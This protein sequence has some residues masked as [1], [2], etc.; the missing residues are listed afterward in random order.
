MDHISF[1]YRSSSHLAF[2]HV[3]AE[4]GAFERHQLDVEYDKKISREDAH[5]LVP[6]GKVEFTSG[7]HVS[8]YAARARGDNWIYLAQ[9]VSVNQLCMVVRQDSE[10]NSVKDLR[11]K[12]FATK[13]RHPALNDWL[14]LKQ[15]GLDVDK[16]EVEIIKFGSTAQD[17][18]AQQ[19]NKSD[20]VAQGYADA[21]FLQEPRKSFAI[22]EGL[23]IVAIE[24]QDMIYYATVSSS[25]PF[26]QKHPEIVKRLLK[27]MLEGVAYLKTHRDESVRILMEKHAK[28]GALDRAAAEALYDELAPR[29]DAKLYPS[30]NAVFNVYEEA[31]RQS[32]DAEKIHPLALWDMHFLREIDDEGFIDELYKQGKPAA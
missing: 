6:T 31:K 11:K 16:D 13:G 30:L 5:A 3:V 2:M 10:I 26:T 12:K 1:P 28:E 27:A 25:L 29:L 20:A 24:P 32:K 8:T 23:R 9:S 17:P 21:C 22:R 19:L 15:S 14:Y 7:N 4:S 18:V